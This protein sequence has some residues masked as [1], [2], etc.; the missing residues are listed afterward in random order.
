MQYNACK[1]DGRTDGRTDIWMDGLKTVLELLFSCCLIGLGV[2]RRCMIKTDC[3]YRFPVLFLFS[4]SRSSRV[5]C[6]V[7]VFLVRSTL[8]LFFFF[9]NVMNDMT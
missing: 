8:S 4:F 3:Y 1:W 5:N 7:S 2:Y 6:T 9:L